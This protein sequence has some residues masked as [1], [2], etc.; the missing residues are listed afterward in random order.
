MIHS[1]YVFVFYSLNLIASPSSEIGFSFNFGESWQKLLEVMSQGELHWSHEFLV[2][3]MKSVE[4]D[5]FSHITW[6]RWKM[7]PKVSILE[8]LDKRVFVEDRL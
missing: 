1:N 3:V 4:S 6:K 7:R 8:R 2:V 5:W